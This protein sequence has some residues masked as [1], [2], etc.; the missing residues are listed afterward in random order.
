[1]G[2]SPSG[3]QL[4]SERGLD[5][6]EVPAMIT[7]S[8][9]AIVERRPEP[10]LR[11]EV[12][13]DEVAKSVPWRAGPTVGAAGFDCVHAKEAAASPSP[14]SPPRTLLS[15]ATNRLPQLCNFLNAPIWP[16]GGFSIQ[17]LR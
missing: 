16:T 12:E 1:M 9:L 17:T 3:D 4:A 15:P 8:R 7:T 5:R 10:T 13:C 2:W 14:H 11:G 6:G